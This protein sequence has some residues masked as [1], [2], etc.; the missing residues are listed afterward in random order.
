MNPSDGDKD[1][2]NYTLDDDRNLHVKNVEGR[3]RKRVESFGSLSQLEHGCDEMIQNTAM[4]QIII[5]SIE[6]GP[7]GQETTTSQLQELNYYQKLNEKLLLENAELRIELSDRDGE[8]NSLRAEVE[9][10]RKLL[11][12]DDDDDDANQLRESDALGFTR[13]KSNMSIDSTDEDIQFSSPSSVDVKRHNRAD[14]DGGVENGRRGGVDDGKYSSLKRIRVAQ[15]QQNNNNNEEVDNVASITVGEEVED[16]E[17]VQGGGSLAFCCQNCTC[18][19]STTNVQL[20]CCHNSISQNSYIGNIQLFHKGCCH[21]ERGDVNLFKS[22]MQINREKGFAGIIKEDGQ[23]FTRAMIKQKHRNAMGEERKVANEEFLAAGDSKIY[24]SPVYAAHCEKFQQ[25]KGRMERPL[26]VLEL[27]SGIGCGTIALKKLRIPLATIVHCDHDPI[28]HE[29]CKFNHNSGDCIDHVYIETFEE[30][31]G[32]GSDPDEVKLAKLIGDHGPFDLV[33]A[34]AP[35]SNYSG[36]N[37]R[38]DASCANAQYLPNVG[39]LITKLNEM[40][41]CTLG[42]DHEVLFVSEN[43]AFKDHDHVNLCYGGL[44]PIHLDAKDFS[45]CKRSRFYWCNVSIAI[46]L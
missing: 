21:K 32:Y 16:D 19:E 34:G 23:A 33:I 40:Q 20:Y 25:R 30:I 37:A 44:E 7:R 4:H 36:V 8:I 27:F 31:Y 26:K 13:K 42:M 29:V 3:K 11:G 46:F 35:C 45:P 6:E 12:A 17:V 14:E 38:R 43:V 10:Q 24:A 22:P 9:K 2:D 28:A 5:N 18:N 39:K 1:C 41:K 15:C